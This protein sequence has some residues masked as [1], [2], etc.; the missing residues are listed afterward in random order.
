M[1]TEEQALMQIDAKSLDM[2]LHPQF[3]P[4]ALKQADKNN[5][6]GKGIAASPGAAQVLSFSPQRTRLSKERRARRSFSSVLK[7]PPK[8]SRV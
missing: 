8:T 1:I 3:D 5:V 2:L 4:E 6:V 7:L